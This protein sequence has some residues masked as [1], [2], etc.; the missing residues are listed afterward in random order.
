MG[1][2][3]GRS[4]GLHCTPSLTCHLQRS[5]ILRLSRKA[6]IGAL[7]AQINMTAHLVS[8]RTAVK[9]KEQHQPFMHASLV[10]CLQFIAY[11]QFIAY[12]NRLRATAVEAYKMMLQT[13]SVQDCVCAALMSETGHL[14][15]LTTFFVTR[16]SDFEA[17]SFKG[18]IVACSFHT[19]Q[20]CCCKDSSQ[21]HACIHSGSREVEDL[22]VAFE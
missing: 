9:L 15:S 21:P 22:T 16:L 7:H 5:N 4:S 14:P 20:A 2:A 19:A 3:A 11:S 1:L 17:F 18:A 8:T 13:W 10:H 12:L 6:G